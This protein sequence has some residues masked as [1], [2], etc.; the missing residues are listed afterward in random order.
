MLGAR[1]KQYRLKHGWSQGE[2]AKRAGV[3]QPLLSYLESGR[4]DTVTTDVAKRLAR[5]LGVSIDYLVGTWD[6]E[7]QAPAEA[8]LPTPAGTRG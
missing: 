1:V 7:E 2:L 3:P 4:R 5:T 8:A 6:E